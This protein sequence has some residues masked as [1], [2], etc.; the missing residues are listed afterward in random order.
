MLLQNFCAQLL[1]P[2]KQSVEEKKGTRKE[3]NDK[4]DDLVDDRKL[5]Y[6]SQ[7][8]M[9]VLIISHYHDYVD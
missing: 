3:K 8:A 1:L 9:V 4:N 5:K 6:K 7:N 2:N